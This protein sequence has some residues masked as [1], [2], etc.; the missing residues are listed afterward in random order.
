[1]I[2]T[3]TELVR[4]PS[5]EERFEYLVLGGGV[6]D[7]TFGFDRY[8]NQN[9][10]HSHEWKSVRNYVIS[11]DYGCNLGVPGF[12]IHESIVV[13]HI[14]PMTADDI[15]HGE[16]WIVDPEFLITTDHETHNDI[17]YGK[18]RRPRPQ[19]VERQSGD[20]KLW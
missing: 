7:P 16:D 3:Y 19:Y 2:R 20:T 11:R 6:G 1:M 5:F 12:E 10:Y 9:F 13:H 18:K 4:L 15:V 8:I 17:H 14:N